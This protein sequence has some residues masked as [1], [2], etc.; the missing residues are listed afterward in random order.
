MTAFGSHVEHATG[1]TGASGASGASGATGARGSGVRNCSS[2]PTSTRAGGQD[3]GSYTNS[4][5]LWG[6]MGKK[7][8]RAERALDNLRTH[9]RTHTRKQRHK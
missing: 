9:V 7:M 2:D 6:T 8:C 3:D 5:K 1:A 4:L